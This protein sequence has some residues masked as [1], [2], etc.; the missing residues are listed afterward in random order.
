MRRNLFFSATFLAFLLPTSG[1][2]GASPPPSL[3][4]R[5][6]SQVLRVPA[7]HFA[8]ERRPRIAFVQLERKD[9]KLDP[10]QKTVTLG[11]K[12]ITFQ[13]RTI[14]LRQ[15][16]KTI[17][18]EQFL[19]EANE[20][21]K[22]LNEFGYTLRDDKPIKIR[23]LFGKEQLELQKKALAHNLQRL[24]PEAQQPQVVC[25]GFASGAGPES[26]RPK[27]PVPF[28]WQWDWSE[29]FGNDRFGAKLDS[30]LHLGAEQANLKL[31]PFFSA[32]VQLPGAEGPLELVKLERTGA[33]NGSSLVLTVMGE[34]HQFTI[35]QR[36]KK[37]LFDKGVDWDAKVTMPAGPLDLE[38]RFGFTG[39]AKVDASWNLQDKPALA[40][41][42]VT[43][44]LSADAFA[45]LGAGYEIVSVGVGGQLK[46][47]GEELTLKGSLKFEDIGQKQ[48]VF[49]VEG[50]ND[51]TLLSGE[52]YVFGEIDLLWYT[53]RFEVELY[54]FDGFHFD[55]TLFSIR[56]QNAPAEKDKHVFLAL[57]ELGGIGAET[58]R[59][60]KLP[61]E[62]VEFV[63][64]V[65]VDG[66]VTSRTLRGI[67]ANGIWRAGKIGPG[68]PVF[69]IPLLSYKRVPIVVEVWEKYRLGGLELQSQLDLAKGPWKA[70]EL[71]YDP[72]EGKFSGTASGTEGELREARGD[73]SYWG[74]RYHGLRFKI[75]PRDL[76]KPAP[77]R[78]R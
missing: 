21:E 70:V 37:T 20:L 48:Y 26:G 67:E 33:K 43:T 68:A 34:K 9:F 66:R 19:R 73:T 42:E 31:D 69:E 49:T 4:N 40:E 5:V 1:A 63:V 17:S 35:D 12:A 71:C 8:V 53:K 58:P 13:G 44:H 6:P 11:Q 56:N 22:K 29:S 41:L 23:Y 62:P 74:E 76:F 28:G 39:K 72:G 18:V 57:E 65:T 47:I 55:N 75:E 36:G 78:A 59:G 51:L 15:A 64:N 38:G 50:I 60:E 77:A 46:L 52:L 32:A 24:A 16:P 14:Y 30:H 2:V 25:Q 45:E 7:E 3:F 10:A 54:A 27:V 61:I